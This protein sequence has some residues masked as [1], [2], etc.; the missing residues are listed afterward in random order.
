[1]AKHKH[2]PVKPPLDEAEVMAG[3]QYIRH[4]LTRF[5][6]DHFGRDASTD[7]L[8]G[9]QTWADV[10]VT[11]YHHRISTLWV[12]EPCVVADMVAFEAT[13]MLHNALCG[14]RMHPR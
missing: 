6:I 11:G 5:A 1:M 12:T 10:F 8:P 13:V 7:H 9:G 14:A 3:E 2:K 4:D